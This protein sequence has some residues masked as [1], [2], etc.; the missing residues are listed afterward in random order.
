M[1]LA[2]QKGKYSSG[3]QQRVIICLLGT[4]LSGAGVGINYKHLLLHNCAGKHFVLQVDMWALVM[5]SPDV[6]APGSH[7]VH[8]WSQDG[9]K[10]LA[11]IL[12]NSHEGLLRSVCDVSWLV[13]G[14]RNIMFAFG[15]FSGSLKL[16]PVKG[17][18]STGARVAEYV[19]PL[20]H[21]NSTNVRG[22]WTKMLQKLSFVINTFWERWPEANYIFSLMYRR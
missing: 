17:I 1:T 9:T 2:K 8:P 15:C 12:C 4:A 3:G 10:C 7:R 11:G 21:N 22:L 5:Y 6:W 19:S 13:L 14:Q 18:P 20:L 16:R